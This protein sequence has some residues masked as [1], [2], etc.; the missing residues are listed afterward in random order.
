MAVNIEEIIKIKLD[1]DE[2]VRSQQ[3][4]F[5]R[6]DRAWG[7]YEAIDGSQYDESKRR[8]FKEEGRKPWQF[9]F[10]AAKTDGLAGSIVAELPDPDWT[11]VVGDPSSLTEAIHETYINDKDLF[12]FSKVLI[13]T[14]RDGCIHSG[15]CEI[16]ISKKYHPAGNICLT[17]VRPGYF[18][19]DPYWITDD[20]NELMVGYKIGYYNPVS[21]K[22]IWEKSIYDI[23]RAIYDLKHGNRNA[24]PQ[25]IKA[26]QLQYVSRVGNEYRV[27]EKHVLDIKNTV[28]LIG[29]KRDAETLYQHLTWIPF[30]VTED[31][32]LLEKFADVN[33]ID[34]ET[35]Q[36]LPYE[37]RVHKVKTITD[38]SNDIMLEDGISKVQCNSLPFLHYTT[39]RTNGKDKGIIESIADLQEMLNERMSHVH[40]M[41]GK[42]SGGSSIINEQLFR[43]NKEKQ[44]FARNSNK[45]GYKFFGDIDGVKRIKEDIGNI[46][47]NPAIFQ[48]VSVIYNELLP[49]IS[50]VSDTMSALSNSEDTGVLFE[51][52]YQMNKISNILFEKYAFQFIN[53]LGEK[54]FYLWQ[55]TYRDNEREIRTR[56][57]KVIVLNKNTD[58]GIINSVANVPRCRVVVNEN[59]S[60]STYQMRQRMQV[61]DIIKSIPQNDTLRL[62][63]ALG[64][65]FGSIA[66]ADK[67]K[68]VMDMV[69]EMNNLKAQL[70]FMT[71]LST[72]KT[73][74]ANNA[75]MT[76]QAE[77]MLKSLQQQQQKVM[78][79]QQ[80]P[81]VGQQVTT[82]EQIPVQVPHEQQQ[83][84]MAAVA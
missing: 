55:N 57:G 44:S 21:M 20:D 17:R 41:I 84:E 39:S 12:N 28:R 61:Q 5:S 69:T 60:S 38:L 22:Q 67:D 24:P 18:I 19:P 33:N 46:N 74:M 53:N 75:A 13:D 3:A 36:E 9:N 30:P 10:A 56:S 32:A 66:M 51:K 80:G 40:E 76:A 48:Q 31:R 26:K 34:W 2:A 77:T 83:P 64:I 59:F 81:P 43:D 78:G 62:N 70:Q 54:Y 73:Q 65:Y 37:I 4:A 42:A 47:V 27:I 14:I 79:M 71:E 1:F 23:D 68:A 50:R 72:M 6:A 45:P 49:L 58:Y 52:K 16:G 29:L 11:P 7:V 35:V 25:D 8:I 63:A 82:N 15:W